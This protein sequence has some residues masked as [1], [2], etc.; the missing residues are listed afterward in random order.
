[1]DSTRGRKECESLMR[2]A[3][4]YAQAMVERLVEGMQGKGVGLGEME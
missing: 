2:V 1:M 3:V 4:R